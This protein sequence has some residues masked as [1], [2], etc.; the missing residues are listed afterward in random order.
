MQVPEIKGM[1]EALRR[2]YVT[3][4]SLAASGLNLTTIS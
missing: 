2:S 4:Q 1:G 3:E